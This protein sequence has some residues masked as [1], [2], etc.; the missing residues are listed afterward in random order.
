[1]LTAEQVQHSQ[2]DVNSIPLNPPPTEEI[3]NYKIVRLLGCGATSN[4]Y[5]GVDKTSMKLVAIKKIRPE[6]T[7]GV[8]HK[9]FAIEASLCGKLQHQNIVSLYEASSGDVNNSYI[10]ME[11]VEGESLEGFASP[12]KLLPVKTVLDVVR[13]A[14]E[15]LNYA[16]QMGVIH[17][18]V[19]P[20]NMLMTEDGQVK[21]TDFGC[22]LLYDSEMT[23]I[24][25][26]GSLSYMSPEQI[27][28][29]ALNHQSDIYSLGSVLYRLLTGHNT[30]NAVDNYSAINQIT[31]HPHIPIGS[32]RVDLPK[33][34]CR[35]VDHSLQKNIA[36]RYQDW[37][38]FLSDLYA[39]SGIIRDAGPAEEQTRF[40]L[41]SHCNFFKDFLTVEIWEV[42]RA[43]QWRNFAR[44]EQII[45]EGEHGFSFFIMLQGSV[46]VSKKQRMLNVINA[47]DCVGE[48]ACLYKGS[49]IRGA[50]VTAHGETIAL[51]ISKN[52]LEGFSKEVCIRMDRAFLRSL[53]EKLTVSNSRVLQLMGI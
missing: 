4:V 48:N 1:M 7:I 46:V 47:G 15:A 13:Q 21:L 40:E 35:I 12:D 50:T 3:G 14:A 51:E 2:L 28:G 5:L 23:Q 36:D 10:V 31:N 20:A 53:N 16:F 19:K 38:E 32:R 6:C 11:Y 42:L 30:F 18:D 41:M 29:I 25:G 52:Q 27:S 44:N 26:A 9:M 22:A 43:S 45:K 33:E 49:P 37:K 39:A 8:Q 34:L 24:T 17:R